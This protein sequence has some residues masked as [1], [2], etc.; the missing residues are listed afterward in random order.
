MLEADKYDDLTNTIKRDC[1]V[2]ESFDIMD[3]SLLVAVHNL[4][5][6]DREEA[7]RQHNNSTDDVESEDENATATVTLAGAS[8]AFACAASPSLLV[9]SHSIQ[10]PHST[11]FESNQAESEP[12]NEENDVP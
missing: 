11:V 4:D 6:A 9:R 5:A 2:L 3:Y 10:R 1:S 12:I 7:E 8:A